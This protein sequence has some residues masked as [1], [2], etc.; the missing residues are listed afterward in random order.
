MSVAKLL[1][2]N[3]DDDGGE[4]ILC[5]SQKAQPSVTQ[6]YHKLS[7]LNTCIHIW[8]RTWEATTRYTFYVFWQQRNLLHL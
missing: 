4:V 2:G 3:D 8:K 1:C 5:F 6:V 7:L